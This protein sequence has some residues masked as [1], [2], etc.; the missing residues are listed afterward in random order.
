M[1]PRDA[2]FESGPRSQLRTTGASA[3]SDRGIRKSETRTAKNRRVARPW[4]V[5]YELDGSAHRRFGRGRQS[6]PVPRKNTVTPS[7]DELCEIPSNAQ[8]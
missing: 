3:N 2:R 4:R 7:A 8:K 6:T 5:I 1:A